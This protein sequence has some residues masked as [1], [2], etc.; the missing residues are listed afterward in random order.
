MRISIDGN[1]RIWGRYEGQS[2]ERK[3]SKIPRFRIVLAK[4]TTPCRWST[5]MRPLSR[6]TSPTFNRTL[7]AARESSSGRLLVEIYQHP[8][9]LMCHLRFAFCNVP[10]RQEHPCRRWSS[11]Y[12]VRNHEVYPARHEKLA[13]SNFPSSSLTAQAFRYIDIHAGK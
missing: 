12:Q 6:V 1:I 13:L 8:L 5:G 7:E 10:E 2:V 4:P 3:R 11:C 9:S